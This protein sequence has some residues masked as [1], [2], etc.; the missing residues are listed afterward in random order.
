MSV[1]F[2]ILPIMVNIIAIL[3]L[4]LLDTEEIHLVLRLP[5]PAQI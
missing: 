3:E 1:E 5:L 2:A 4:V